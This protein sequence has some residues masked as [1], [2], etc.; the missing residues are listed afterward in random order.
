MGNARRRP[1][2]EGGVEGTA[3][4]DKPEALSA[5]GLDKPI[6]K[7]TVQRTEGK[8]STWFELGRAGAKTFVRRASDA[9]V[10]EVDPAKVDELMKAVD[11]L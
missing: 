10:L 5:Y 3:F 1:V 9:A 2:Q 11:G 4:I 8:G 6:L 7:A